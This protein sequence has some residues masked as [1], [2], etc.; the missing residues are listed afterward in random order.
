M[1]ADLIIPLRDHPRAHHFIQALAARLWREVYAAE[2]H[3]TATWFVEVE[4]CDA[5]GGDASM[6]MFANTKRGYVTMTRPARIVGV[7]ASGDLLIR[8]AAGL[9]PGMVYVWRERARQRQ[10]V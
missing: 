5:I 2:H 4:M 10:L 6:V 3:R 1:K 8:T 9:I 7:D